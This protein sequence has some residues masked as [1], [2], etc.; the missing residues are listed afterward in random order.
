MITCP[1]CNTSYA[2]FQSSC[3]KCGGPIPPPVTVPLN[4]PPRLPPPPPAPRPFADN[5]AWRLM[6]SDGWAIA[7][8]VF[9]LLGGIFTIIGIPLTLALVTAF[10]GLPFTGLGLTFLAAGAFFFRRSYQKAR[11]TV[12]VLREGQTAN[13]QIDSVAMNYSVRVN[14]RH[15]WIIKYSFQVMGKN[16]EGQVSTLDQPNLYLKTGNPAYVLYLPETP[17]QNS[18]YPHP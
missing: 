6:F 14:N 13:G 17:E 2:M 7:S 1:W 10:V 18:L 4:A 11:T 8:M 3:D 9:L 16:Y 5:Y 12:K 15:P